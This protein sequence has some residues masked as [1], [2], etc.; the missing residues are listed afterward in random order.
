[1][2]KRNQIG[3]SISDASIEMI[4]IDQPRKGASQVV[5]HS[6]GKLPSG[7]V[8]NGAIV[9]QSLFATALNKLYTS[10]KPKPYTTR[11]IVVSLPENVAFTHIFRF[12]GIMT[13]EDIESTIK[14][15]A[16]DIIPFAIDDLYTTFHIIKQNEEHT[17]VLFSAAEKEVI[18]GYTEAIGQT[19]FNLQAL[20]IEASALIRALVPTHRKGKATLIIDF[21]ATATKFILGDEDGLKGSFSLPLGG[22]TITQNL[23]NSLGISLKE[24]EILKKKAPTGKKALAINSV[25]DDYVEKVTRKVRQIIRWYEDNNPGQ[26]DRCILTGGGSALPGLAE[27]L[28][29]KCKAFEANSEIK[30]GNPWQSVA[31]ETIPNHSTANSKL[32]APAVGAAF[33]D[34]DSPVP[35]VNFLEALRGKKTVAKFLGLTNGKS[36]KEAEAEPTE[37]ESTASFR[38]RLGRLSEVKKIPLT[39]LSLLVI[40]G[41]IGGILY[42]MFFT[43]RDFSERTPEPTPAE[44][45]AIVAV[46]TE[47]QLLVTIDT[48]NRQDTVPATLTTIEDYAFSIVYNLEATETIDAV[49]TGEITIFNETDSVQPLIANTR[50]L[51]EA[52]VL[53]RL[54]EEVSVPANGSVIA[55]IYADEAGASGNIEENETFTIPGL[56]AELQSSIYGENSSPITGGTTT[57]AVYTES[58]EQTALDTLKTAIIKSPDT[59]IEELS[60]DEYFFEE[61]IVVD[62]DDVVSSSEFGETTSSVELTGTASINALYARAGDIKEFMY[63]KLAQEA[64]SNDPE[65]YWIDAVLNLVDV[66]PGAAHPE[67]A[68]A[69]LNIQYLITK[70]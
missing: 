35:D 45:N 26:L 6:A 23:S 69:T 58:A 57:A 9:N 70:D 2:A 43:E 51:S 21:G 18:Q 47:S 62:S 55:N 65:S 37:E 61:L 50:F 68:N 46:P 15:E 30:F 19:D 52:D 59:F 25:I 12:P 24:A 28:K 1:M 34:E 10:A 29:D 53:F 33:W 14:F 64:G 11:D 3:I 31:K 32:Y 39:I 17:D 66:D 36:T 7:V 42:W 8:K 49:A 63:Q 4:E 40:F 5:A 22:I 48:V 41:T 13:K 60:G 56:P 16:E 54:S 38:D 20:D 44:T 67:L 27:R